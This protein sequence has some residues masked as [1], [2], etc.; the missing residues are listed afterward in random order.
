[1]IGKNT[2]SLLS[3]MKDRRGKEGEWGNVLENLVKIFTLVLLLHTV[4]YLITSYRYVSRNPGIIALLPL[5]VLVPVG[6]GK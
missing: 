6:Y 1:M 3:R 4:Y 5:A 2:A